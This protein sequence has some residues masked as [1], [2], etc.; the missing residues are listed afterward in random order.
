[1][2]IQANKLTLRRYE[3]ISSSL[4][5]SVTLPSPPPEAT[6]SLNPSA[7]S[8][9]GLNASPS[10]KPIGTIRFTPS[11]GKISRLAVLKEYRQYGFGK[12]LM[13][14]VEEHARGHKA[15][16]MAKIILD[17][18]QNKGKAVRLKLHSQMP[19]VPF[20]TRLGFRKE[21]EVFDE[22]GGEFY[23]VTYKWAGLSDS[24]PSEDDQG[25]PPESI[26]KR[27]DGVHRHRHKLMYKV[28][29]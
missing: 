3:P 9:A 15:E 17:S 28:R 13:L 14:A 29:L 12:E 22:E 23:A 10:T 19:V 1:V 21:G 16:D 4:L 8:P 18:P 5:L 25:Y 7:L 20:Y 26:E 2:A 24:G 6:S 11:I 27:I